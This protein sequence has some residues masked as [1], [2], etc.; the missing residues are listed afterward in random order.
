MEFSH[1]F[2]CLVSGPTKSGKTTW[3]IKF[4]ENANLLINPPPQ[5]IIY[6][7][8]EWQPNYNRL[9]N[10]SNIQLVEGLPNLIELKQ[11]A[12]IPKLLVLDDFMESFGSA[13]DKLSTL[14]TR[15]AHH[16]NTS[17]IHLVQNLF[18]GSR[19]A[20]VNAHYIVLMK[21]PSDK[22][23]IQALGRQVCPGQ[24]KFVMEAYTDATTPK[25]G[26][27]LVDLSPTSEDDY[28]FRTGIFPD[29]VDCVYVQKV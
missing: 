12:H 14:F 20:R 4:L 13:K 23:Q 28:R 11:T 16:W 19:T 29:E 25:F 8:N 17:C 21:N 5:Q 1:P 2:T 26:Y 9:Q 3:T 18:H 15:G 24:Q 6:C 27:L 22:L 7:Y 10:L